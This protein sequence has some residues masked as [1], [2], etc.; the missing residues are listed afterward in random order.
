[1][2]SK[3]LYLTGAI[4]LAISLLPGCAAANRAA[5]PATATTSP[6]TDVGMPNPASVYCQERAGRL[7]IRTDANG[8]QYGVCVFLDGSECDEWEYFRGECSPAGGADNQPG[9]FLVKQSQGDKTPEITEL[10]Q[11]AVQPVIAWVGHISS[12]QPGSQYDDYLSLMPAGSGEIGLSGVNPEVE[13]Q[14][15]SLRD[16]TGIEE[17]PAFWGNLTCDVPA[18]GGCQLL[19]S[20]VRYGQ[21]LTEPTPVEG[22]QGS[23]VCSHFNNSPSDICGNAFILEGD[24]PIWYGIWSADPEILTQ[25]ESLRDS[26]HIIQIWG[27]LISGVPDVNGNQ[28]QVD[29]IEVSTP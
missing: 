14:I 29:Q 3:K 24:F 2:S 11:N 5:H 12:T 22:W 7:E 4:L 8:D 20:E 27:Q 21:Y 26:G 6:E 13:A 28:I 25:I 10:E 9:E 17:F 16:G 23:V 15:V 1:M 19:V 18:Y